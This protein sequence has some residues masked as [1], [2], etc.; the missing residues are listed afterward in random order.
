MANVL[1]D[2]TIWWVAALIKDFRIA[3]EKLSGGVSAGLV[4]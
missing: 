1:K 3:I 4:E 2:K